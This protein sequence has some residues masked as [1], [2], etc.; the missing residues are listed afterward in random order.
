VC[1]DHGRHY[2]TL[3]PLV[4]NSVK[5]IEGDILDKE[6][7]ARNTKGA[8]VILH[9]AGGGGNEACMKD[10]AK[11]VMTNIVGT[12]T[13]LKAAQASH[14]DRF[15]FASSYIAYSTF[16]KREMPLTE[17]M[18]LRPDDFYGALKAASERE[19]M[20]S[21]TD[22]VILRISNVYGYGLGLGH[23]WN[24]VT[25]RFIKSGFESSTIPVYGSGKQKIDV[26]HIEDLCRAIS[27]IINSRHVR[28]ECFNIGSGKGTPVEDIARTV[29]DTFKNK[30]RKSVIIERKQAPPGK[31]WPDRWVSV[32]KI[33]RQLGW[34]P[35]MNLESG[36]SGL[37][38]KYKG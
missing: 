3:R 5:L 9:L 26:V 28:N 2:S 1:L 21:G 27:M 18:E 34:K 4:G 17:D 36:I 25:G 23:E 15:I 13:L 37:I 20:D 19:I 29:Q 6:L 33:G 30:F 24:G 38:A 8:D 35:E 14:V 16:L 32:S 31:I 7:I 12:H 10:P 22:Y 11:A